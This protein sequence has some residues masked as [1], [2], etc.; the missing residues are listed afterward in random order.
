MLYNKKTLEKAILILQQRGKS[1]V[2]PLGEIDHNYFLLQIQT[3]LWWLISLIICYLIHFN[4]ST[5]DSWI[6][7]CMYH[8]CMILDTCMCTVS[9]TSGPWVTPLTWGRLSH[10]I[11]SP[12]KRA[13]PYI[14][15]NLNPLRM[16]CAKFGWNRP[17]GSGKNISKCRQCIFAIVL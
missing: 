7:S 6:C 17:S 11:I 2:C 12:W 9:R 1:S 5:T 10:A 3:N 14:W 4:I 15:T 8:T 13:W 16:L